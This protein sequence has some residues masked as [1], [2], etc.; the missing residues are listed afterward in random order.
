MD[1]ANKC[2]KL[3]RGR[4]RFLDGE[5]LV[6]RNIMQRLLDS[7]GPAN[8]DFF[9]ACIHAQSEMHSAIA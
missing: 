5:D 6:G 2:M 9:D 7:A 1:L 3:L 4:A 8:F